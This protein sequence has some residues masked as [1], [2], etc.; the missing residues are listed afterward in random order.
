MDE[1]NKEKMTERLNEIM[2]E[3][4]L[5]TYTLGE[6]LH[7]SPATISRYLNGK[8]SPKI[9]AIEIIAGRY[10]LNPAWIMGHDV[11]KY[12]RKSQE[13]HTLAAHKNKPDE[14][15]TEEEL[16]EIERFKEFVKQKRKS[17]K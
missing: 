1:L 6:I 5:N 4:D 9:T 10:N 15:W 14:V 2:K 16:K 8:M 11:P 13:I 3:F 7:L 17:D 12:M